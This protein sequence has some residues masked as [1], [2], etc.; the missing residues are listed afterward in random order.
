MYFDCNALDR[1]DSA[2][3][4]ANSIDNHENGKNLANAGGEEMDLF[5]LI[6]AGDFSSVKGQF[7]KLAPSGD[8]ENKEEK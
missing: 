8:M 6:S 5:D 3:A 4:A 7:T 1:I 2:S